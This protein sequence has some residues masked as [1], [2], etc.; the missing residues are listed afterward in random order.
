MTQK[1]TEGDSKFSLH[2]KFIKLHFSDV[3]QLMNKR[4][5]QTGI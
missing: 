1:F 2:R 3:P 5:A 4:T